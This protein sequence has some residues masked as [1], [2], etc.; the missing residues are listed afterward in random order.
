[1]QSFNQRVKFFNHQHP[2]LTIGTDWPLSTTM[3]MPGESPIKLKMNIKLH[4]RSHVLCIIKF[5]S[6][7]V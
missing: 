5:D 6:S 2:Y 7:T 1:M 3:G 4:T